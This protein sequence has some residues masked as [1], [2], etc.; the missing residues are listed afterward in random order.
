MCYRSISSSILARIFHGPSMKN[1][2]MREFISTRVS[3]ALEWKC[4]KPIWISPRSCV[5]SIFCI[6]REH[7]AFLRQTTMIEVALRRH[8]SSHPRRFTNRIRRQRQWWR[9]KHLAH[10]WTPFQGW[11]VA[12]SSSRS[13][14]ANERR[15]SSNANRPISIARILRWRMKTNRNVAYRRRC[16]ILERIFLRLLSPTF[17]RN[18]RK[19]LITWL[20]I[21]SIS[22][23]TSIVW[24]RAN[25]ERWKHPLTTM[26]TNKASI[27]HQILTDHINDHS[28]E[29]NRRFTRH[30]WSLIARMHQQRPID[31]SKRQISPRWSSNDDASFP[32][33]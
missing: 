16:S 17:N 1:C 24:R 15:W 5:T 21:T 8:R 3:V 30:R 10:P 18:V 6:Q 33:P 27:H 14:R 25:K 2:P 23:W 9:R 32:Y 28:G 20:K 22:V 13:P 7:P 31:L 11:S 26:N 19:P 12:S 4:S 29:T